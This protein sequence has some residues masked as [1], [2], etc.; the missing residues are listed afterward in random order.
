MLKYEVYR[1]WFRIVP[2]VID[3]LFS[4]FVEFEDKRDAEDAVRELNG[5]KVEGER[6]SVEM[7]KVFH[8]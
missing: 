8:A 1:S 5:T 2:I 7:S 4:A 6:I 3:K